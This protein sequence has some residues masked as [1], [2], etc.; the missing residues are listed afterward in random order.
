MSAN[1]H[2]PILTTLC[3]KKELIYR[4]RIWTATLFKNHLSVHQILNN[5]NRK[6]TIEK[7]KGENKQVID[8]KNFLTVYSV[9]TMCN[10]LRQ[11][12]LRC[13]TFQ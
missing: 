1:E 13:N 9:Y 12:L 3:K 11:M 4:K 5:N 6:V 7:N 8:K 2:P 10:E